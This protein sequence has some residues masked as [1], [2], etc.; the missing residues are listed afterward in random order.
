MWQQHAV[1][2]GLED[3]VDENPVHVFN[4]DSVTLD[5]LNP[6]LYVRMPEYSDAASRDAWDPTIQPHKHRRDIY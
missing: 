3:M 6:T 4:M 2:A 1:C 5:V